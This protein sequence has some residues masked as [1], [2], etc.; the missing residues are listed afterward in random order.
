MI[1]DTVS[2]AGSVVLRHTM[3][4]TDGFEET[5]YALFGLIDEARRKQPGSARRLTLVIEGHRLSD[6]RFD[7]DAGEIQQAFLDQLMPYLCSARVPLRAVENP[8]QDDDLP[9]L[10]V[11][12]DAEHPEWGDG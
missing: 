3:G 4:A 8:F 12:D 10:L 9:D 11:L 5:A 1:T 6:G 7:A 2:Q